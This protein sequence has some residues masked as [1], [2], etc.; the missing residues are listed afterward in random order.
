M[1]VFFRLLY[2]VKFK[3]FLISFLLIKMLVAFAM[4]K[5]T[6]IFFF[7]KNITFIELDL[8]SIKRLNV[9]LGSTVAQW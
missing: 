5:A 3:L 8:K 6:N 9:S 4:A 2:N 1:R 7:S